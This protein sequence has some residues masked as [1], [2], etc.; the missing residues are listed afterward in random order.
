MC[1]GERACLG[2]GALIKLSDAQKI[3]DLSESDDTPNDFACE[4][5][6]RILEDIADIGATERLHPGGRGPITKMA[7]GIA[8]CLTFERPP[9]GEELP[10]ERLPEHHDAGSEPVSEMTADVGRAGVKRLSV[11]GHD[12]VGNEIA[13]VESRGS[14]PGEFAVEDARLILGDQDGA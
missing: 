4:E 12:V 9:K 2:M 13:D 7:G 14:N 6:N 5:G 3:F 1:K 10:L 8:I 11:P